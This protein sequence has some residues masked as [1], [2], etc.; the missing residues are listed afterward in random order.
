MPKIFPILVVFI[1]AV[2]S[3]LVQFPS[4]T[5]ASADWPD[6]RFASAGFTHPIL[7]D[8][9]YYIWDNLSDPSPPNQI[10]PATGQSFARI[11]G[12]LDNRHDGLSCGS[13][14]QVNIDQIYNA[15]EP[16]IIGL[17]SN[18]VNKGNVWFIGNESNN[19]PYISP[20]LHAYQFQKYHSL[21][22]SLD[23][24]A[25]ITNSGLLF[26]GNG[27][28]FTSANGIS[29]L[30][31]FLSALSPTQYPDIY[32]LHLYPNG[33]ETAQFNANIQQLRDFKNYLSTKGE[34][35]KP[36]W[37]T[38]F[39]ITGTTD[40]Q[41]VNSYMNTLIFYFIN[42]NLAQKWFW[43]LGT[44]EPGY[45]Y[46]ALTRDGAITATGQNYKFLTE[47]F[48]NPANSQHLVISNISTT[49][50]TANSATFNW[51]TS[52]PATT[53]VTYGTT[54]SLNSRTLENT[55]LVT[56]HSVTVSTLFRNT[57]YYY[58]V[59]SK[60]VLGMPYSSEIRSFKTA[61]R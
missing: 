46:I 37:V 15:E 60:N 5:S 16:K 30:D 41:V 27:N 49:N 33:V 43:F 54:T 12:K 3:T 20:Q 9:D 34:G 21:I 56:N 38:E 19:Y 45:D 28:I 47:Y 17:L 55:S 11:V 32:N 2:Y 23:P 58:R 18:D 36:I 1:T 26:F 25:K 51:L 39:G 48:Q 10:D 44:Y 29:Y 14:N 52:Q 22:K 13:C 50:V 7:G 31:A 6:T 8:L 40:Q 57:T 42:E 4:T 61:R 59:H 35:A 24:T 53:W